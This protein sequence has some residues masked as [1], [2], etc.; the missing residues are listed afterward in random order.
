MTKT[1]YKNFPK[2]LTNKSE[3][4]KHASL[5][6]IEH[7]ITH[8]RPSPE[9]FPERNLAIQTETILLHNKCKGNIYI[10]PKRNLQAESIRW[11]YQL[12]DLSETLTDPL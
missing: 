6:Y 11:K 7:G 3:D 5:G 8:S 9:D 2:K 4:K 1:K 10:V 12:P